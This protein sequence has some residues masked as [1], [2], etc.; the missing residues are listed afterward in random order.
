MTKHAARATTKC[1]ILRAEAERIALRITGSKLADPQSAQQSNAILMEER[2]GQPNEI[3]EG[4]KLSVS[5][6]ISLA[7]PQ[8][9]KQTNAILINERN[10]Y[11]KS[12]IL[13]CYRCCPKIMNSAGARGEAPPIECASGRDQ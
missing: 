10:K 12:C 1:K 7:D 5:L 13:D 9:A 11:R 6:N 8:S 2:N 3:F 4:E